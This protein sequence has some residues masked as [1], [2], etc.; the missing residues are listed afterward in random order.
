MNTTN[1]IAIL[2]GTFDPV[3][4]GHILP[5]KHV[6][7]WLGL[8][9]IYLMPANIPPHKSSVS[10]SAKQRVDMVKLV[11]GDD[12][13]FT[14]DER[15]INRTTLSYT[16]DTL[17]EIK[18]AH[19]DQIIFF[20]IGMDSLLTFPQWHQWQDIL[21]LCHLV[22]NC[23]PDYPLE[24]LTPCH[25]ALLKKHQ[26]DKTTSPQSITQQAGYILFP[27]EIACDISS[28]QIRNNIKNNKKCEHLLPNKVEN[29][30]RDNQLYCQSL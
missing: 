5:A 30:I 28:T 19:P 16:V 1:K 20:I 7:Q 12:E 18:Q 4:N 27:P 22:V 26:L 2:G 9:Q 24:K 10:A 25:Q 21:T 6:A 17:R 29:Y 8:A 13:L 14:C 23:R 15:E 3:H 11:C